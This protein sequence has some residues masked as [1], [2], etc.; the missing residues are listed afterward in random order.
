MRLQFETGG[1]SSS[2]ICEPH[3]RYAPLETLNDRQ[4][5]IKRKLLFSQDSNDKLSG[6][7]RAIDLAREIIKPPSISFL[8]VS[9]I[10]IGLCCEKSKVRPEYC[11]TYRA[12]F[13]DHKDYSEIGP[14]EEAKHNAGLVSSFDVDEEYKVEP[15][16]IELRT[17]PALEP[18]IKNQPDY[19]RA[20]AVDVGGD[21]IGL[22]IWIDEEGNL[23]KEFH[24]Y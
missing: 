24:F 19:G 20:Y 23:Q 1:H 5:G 7:Q 10:K 22:W 8:K 15:F 18:W 21:D 13:K 11:T 14:Q 2:F 12:D 9:R 3:K 16:I 4:R 17:D 6:I